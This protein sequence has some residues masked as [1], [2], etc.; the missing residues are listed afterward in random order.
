[1][2]RTAVERKQAVIVKHG[3]NFRWTVWSSDGDWMLARQ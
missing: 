2:T 1:M 3:W